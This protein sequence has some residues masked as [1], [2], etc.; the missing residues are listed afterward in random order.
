MYQYVLTLYDTLCISLESCTI[1]H[2][3]DNL[4]LPSPYQ[5]SVFA[6]LRNLIIKHKKLLCVLEILECT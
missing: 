6:L 4:Y 5:T 2:R 1:H 3:K